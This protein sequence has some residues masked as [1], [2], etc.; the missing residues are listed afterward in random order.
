MASIDT[1]KRKPRRTLGTPSYKYRNRFAY[2][3]LAAGSL[4]FGI[5]SLTPMQ[6]I[7]NERITQ[8]LV[9]QS[10]EEKDRRALFDFAAPRRADFIRE[11]I[12]EA[13]QLAKER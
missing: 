4:L 13:E 6:R 11:A 5:W 2:A 12:E 8:A 10:E 3:L 9:T 7:A 1:S